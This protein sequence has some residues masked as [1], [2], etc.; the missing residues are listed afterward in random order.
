[1]NRRNFLKSIAIACGAAVACPAK[2]LRG[3]TK[4]VVMWVCPGK[5]TPTHRIKVKYKGT[6]SIEVGELLVW[7]DEEKTCVVR[8]VFA[9][10]V[11]ET[12]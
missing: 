12:T 4:Q 10:V 7:G 5:K 8:A 6:E 1:M 3:K 2:L 9:G 11:S